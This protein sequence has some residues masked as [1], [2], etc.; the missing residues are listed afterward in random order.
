MSATRSASNT[1]GSPDRRS[2]SSVR[3]CTGVRSSAT[4]LTRP[5][6]PRGCDGG[7]DCR[8]RIRLVGILGGLVGR[9]AFFNIV[10]GIVAAA[11]VAGLIYREVNDDGSS[12]AP[13]TVATATTSTTSPPPTTD[14]PTTVAD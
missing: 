10:L 12:A 8:L 3:R 5:T 9:P 7:R 4:S 13:I 11:L 2:A 1:S 6:V 14:V